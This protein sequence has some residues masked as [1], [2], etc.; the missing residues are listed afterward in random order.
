MRKAILLAALG[1]GVS[2]FAIACGGG[3][4]K[5]IDLGDG[6]E[7]TIGG[8]LPDSFPDDFPI[9]DGADFQGA[10]TAKQDGIEG[11]VATWTTG[12]D[13]DDVTAFYDEE[14]A[15][16]P[17][18][19]QTEGTAGG[20]AYWAVQNSD[21][22]KAAYV[23]VSESDGE[24]TI[25]ATVSDDPNQASSDGDDGSDDGSSDDGDSSSDDGDDGSSSDGDDGDV[26]VIEAELPDEVDLPNDFP[27]DLVPLLDDA[28][29][30][31]ANT[32][33]SGGVTAYTVAYYTEDT[34]DE[35]ASYYK[36]ELEGKGYTQSVQ[37]SDNNGIYAAYAE[38]ADGT[39]KIIVVTAS[40]SDV[41]GYRQVVLQVTG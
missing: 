12:D 4:K 14:F 39:G 11:T 22:D 32:I 21:S 2:V 35:V 38:N 9:Y 18:A 36:G 8:D 40:D 41:D 31:S 17:W 37:T 25:L 6:N 24:V 33:T 1:I 29:V 13:L 20:S 26:P 34:A 23:S 27:T 10:S 5:T 3:D 16:G 15:D 19:I 28:H 7:V 30:A